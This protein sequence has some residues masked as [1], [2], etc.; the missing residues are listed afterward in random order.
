MKIGSDRKE[1]KIS[2]VE[3][4]NATLSGRGGLAFLLRYIDNTGVCSMIEEKNGHLRQSGKGAS[5]GE[6]ARQFMAFCMDGTN[7]SIARFDELKKDPGYAAV[8]ERQVSDLLSTASVKRFFGKFNGT[9]HASYRSVLNELFIWRLRQEKPKVVI[10]H[11]DT[12]VLDNNDAKSREGCNVTYKKVLGFQPLQINWGPY[13][14]DM[15]FRSAAPM[16]LPSIV[17]TNPIDCGLA[18]NCLMHSN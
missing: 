3:I 6:C 12:M 17:A 9:A 15:H 2:D 14:V 13:I 7:H 10:L 18:K 11:L 5:I 16:H 8:Q 4:T 1:S